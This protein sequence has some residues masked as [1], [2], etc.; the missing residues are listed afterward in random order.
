MAQS[1]TSINTNSE[2]ESGMIPSQNVKYWYVWVNTRG[3]QLIYYAMLSD[4][5]NPPIMSF[6]GQHFQTENGADVFVGNTKTLL[7][8]YRDKNGD[9]IPQADFTSGFNSSQNEILYHLVTN[10]SVSYELIPLEKT[11]VNGVPHY[12]WGITYQTIDGFLFNADM[13][14]FAFKVAIDYIQFKY[15]FY[16][17]GNVSYT[18]TSFAMSGLAPYEPSSEDAIPSLDGLS[19]SLLYSTSTISPR[20]FSPYVNGEPYDSTATGEAATPTLSGQIMVEDAKAYEFLFDENYSLS[21]NGTVESHEVKSEAAASS[22]VPSYLTQMNWVFSNL[23]DVID[24][25]A[26]FPSAIGLGV[27]LNLD[28][29]ASKFLYRICYPTWSGAAVEHDPTAIAYFHPTSDSSSGDNAFPTTWALV[30]GASVVVVAASFLIYLRKRR[31]QE[32]R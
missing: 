16:V 31:H 11:V 5:Y 24:L 9:G 25:G 29:G 12:T 4:I 23:E 20:A 13:S 15:D 1:G 8:V 32:S 30:A 10:S 6:L 26:M 2:Y 27:R 19:L 18:K 22:S 21:R 7:E 28:V 3:T 14:G 17:L